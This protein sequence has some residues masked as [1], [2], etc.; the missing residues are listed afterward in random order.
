MESHLAQPPRGDSGNMAQ[1][2]ANVLGSLLGLVLCHITASLD[3]LS[4][5]KKKTV[6]KRFLHCLHKVFIQHSIGQ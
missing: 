1:V 5:K 2:M 3:C 4:G 6:R